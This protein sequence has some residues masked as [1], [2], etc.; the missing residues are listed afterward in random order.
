MILH[1]IIMLLLLIVLVRVLLG[2]VPS[3]TSGALAICL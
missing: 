1:L 3:V 2:L